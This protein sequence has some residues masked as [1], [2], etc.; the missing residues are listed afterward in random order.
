MA[1]PKIPPMYKHQK[2][3]VRVGLQLPDHIMYDTSDPGTGKTR[4]QIEM[5]KRRKSRQATLVVAPKSLL[6][7]VW[8]ADFHKFLPGTRVAIASAGNRE[9]AFAEDADVYVINTDGVTWLADQPKRFLNGFDNLIIDEITTFKHRNSQRSKAMA[10]IAQRFEH[11]AGLT[12]TPDP[13]SVTEMWHQV[14]ILDGGQ[15]L[16]RSFVQF[17]NAVSIAEQ[18]GPQPNMLRWVDRESAPEAVAGLIADIT[19]RNIFEECVDIPPQ[20]VSIVPYQLTSKQLRTYRDMEKVSIAQASD[21]AIISAINGAAL[22]TK[23]LQIAS[24][25]VYQEVST[26]GKK[27]ERQGFAFIDKARYELV[28]EL[29]AARKHSVVFF[30]W[31][32][33]RELLEAEFKKRKIRYAVIAGGVTDKARAEIVADYAKGLY[34]VLLAHPRSAAHGL[35]LT[36]ATTVIWVTPT[37][38][39]EEFIQGNRRIYRISQMFKT[40][41]LVIKAVGTIEEAVVENQ[42]RLNAKQARTLDLFALYFE[43]HR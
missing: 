27:T 12:G 25:A 15:R 9:S 11:R 43:E 13:L 39:P 26:G 18:I 42:E 30:N 8:A 19:I 28:G 24:G 34:Q 16:G 20:T 22:R 40:E 38:N 6:S 17:R 31:S 4:V 21:G 23:L 10:K 5:F 2:K 37:A 7:A 3:S 14:K 41:V 35:T 32:H 29:V 1:T 36:K 33:Q